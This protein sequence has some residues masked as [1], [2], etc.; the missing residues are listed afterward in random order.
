MTFMQF[1]FFEGLENVSVCRCAGVRSARAVPALQRAGEQGRG[2]AGRSPVWKPP[3]LLPV[4]FQERGQEFQVI[5]A[6]CV[7]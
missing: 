2:R 7:A 6:V 4:L 3:A 1:I 5:P